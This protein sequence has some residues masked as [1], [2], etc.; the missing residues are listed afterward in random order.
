MVLLLIRDK[1]C[2]FDVVPM[3]GDHINLCTKLIRKT[4]ISSS[5]IKA[6]MT[7]V[8]FGKELLHPLKTCRRAGDGGRNEFVS[9]GPLGFHVLPPELDSVVGSHVGLPRLIGPT[10]QTRQI[11]TITMT[12]KNRLIHPKN[13]SRRSVLA[14]VFDEVVNVP[15]APELG[16]DIEPS[17]GC[18]RDGI[19]AP[20]VH[21]AKH[22]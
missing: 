18:C 12:K 8:T 7:S 20:S 6:H 15:I 9:I 14:N 13:P 2:R 19:A 22:M 17:G 4:V 1:V 5:K 21:A 10:N 16:D 3:R 11:N